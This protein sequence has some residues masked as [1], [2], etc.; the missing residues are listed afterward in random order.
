MTADVLYSRKFSWGKIFVIFVG[1][2]TSTKFAGNE[3]KRNFYSRKPLFLE[4]KK[5]FYPTKITRYT[6]SKFSKYERIEIA[7]FTV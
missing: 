7:A 1:K 5:L 4:L 3:T 2:L 6:V